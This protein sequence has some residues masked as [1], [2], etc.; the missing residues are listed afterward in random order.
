MT[1]QV[2]DAVVLAGG[3]GRRLGGVSKAEVTVGDRTMLD[4]VLAAVAGARAVVV[5]GPERLARPGVPT[6]L[7]DP[8]L[9][10]PV[11]GL[12]AGLAALDRGAADD[13]PVVVLACDVPLAGPAVPVLLD[14]LAADGAADGAALVAADGHRQPLVAAYRRPALRSALA[15]RAAD[16][17]V[18]GCSM[19]R[20]LAG[21][22]LVDVPDATGA[23]ADGDTWEA[24]AELAA[25]L[26]TGR[27]GEAPMGGTTAG[28]GTS[29]AA[30]GGHKPVGS[31]LH[32]WVAQLVAELGVDPDAVDVEAV[33]DLAREAASGVARPAVPLTAYLVGCAVGARGGGRAAFD[34]VAQRVTG[35]AR[36][37]AEPA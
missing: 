19:K 20:L 2:Y 21:L 9:G 27:Q 23:A 12:D 14:A 1:Q 3:E 16:G 8:P 15:A 7:E 5:V 34:D 18:H 31:E 32:R 13:V 29:S 35:L 22:R 30:G 24:V 33:L 10:G 36:A 6:V 4:H 26:A 25:V 17:G 11:A 37:F 28:D